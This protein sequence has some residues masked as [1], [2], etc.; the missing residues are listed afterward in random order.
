MSHLLG[1]LFIRYDSLRHACRC[2]REEFCGGLYAIGKAHLGERPPC[3]P[4]FGSG[5][6]NGM[7]PH[8]S[9]LLLLEACFQIVPEEPC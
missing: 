7:R 2:P 9:L 6:K 1:V 4:R 3:R 5:V 8:G